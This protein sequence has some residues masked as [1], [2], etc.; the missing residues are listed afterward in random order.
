MTPARAAEPRASSATARA[1]AKRRV[2]CA[3]STGRPPDEPAKRREPGRPDSA[4]RCDGAYTGPVVPPRAR[5]ATVASAQRLRA[6]CRAPHR[7]R[8]GAM[9]RALPVCLLLLALLSF[10]AHA[11]DVFQEGQTITVELMNGDKLTGL[12]LQA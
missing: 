10:S 11:Q 5:S 8:R 4:T 1:R 2:R 3:A 9:R 6:W 7:S 12:L